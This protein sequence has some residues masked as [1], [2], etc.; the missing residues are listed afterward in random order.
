MMSLPELGRA[1]R[2]A[3]HVGRVDDHGVDAVARGRVDLLLGLALRDRVGVD[4]AGGVEV[5]GGGLVARRAVGGQPDRDDRRGVDQARHPRGDR[6]RDDVA[7][8]GDV[9]RGHRRRDLALDRDGSGAVEDGVGVGERRGERRDRGEVGVDPADREVFE[10]AG[11]CAR[12]ARG[13]DLVTGG[14]QLGSEVSAEQTTRSRDD[15]A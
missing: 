13:D 14:E 4:Q 8:A 11:L 9:R 10:V 1:S 2:A 6:R 15:D 3:E 7:G 12:A 5:P